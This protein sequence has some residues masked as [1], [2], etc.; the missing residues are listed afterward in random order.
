[1]PRALPAFCFKLP[2]KAALTGSRGPWIASERPTLRHWIST[3]AWDSSPADLKGG[4]LWG[5]VATIGT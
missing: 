3:E 1:M 2:P 5:R 4:A